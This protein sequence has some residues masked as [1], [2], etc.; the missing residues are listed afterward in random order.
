MSE[1]GTVCVRLF[2]AC[3]RL[4]SSCD[5]DGG[6]VPRPRDIFTAVSEA[7]QEH[8]YDETLSG[9][10]GLWLIWLNCSLLNV[11]GLT[12][13]DDSARYGAR[14]A[15]PARGDFRRLIA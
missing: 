5:R 4:C 12:G 14:S 8:L 3:V 9:F 11:I 7:L 15:M 10:W 1:A 13:I 2:A 6:A